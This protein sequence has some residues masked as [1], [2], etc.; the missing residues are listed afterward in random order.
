MKILKLERHAY[1]PE[2]N[3]IHLVNGATIKAPHI[4]SVREFREKIFP[5]YVRYKRV[6]EVSV[7]ND[8]Y[9]YLNRVY[10]VA[11]RT[12]KDFMRDFKRLPNKHNVNGTTIKVTSVE[13]KFRALKVI[14]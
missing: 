14:Q 2:L 10:K 8:T 11:Y 6:I 12:L 7:T 13:S 9:E 1:A 3:C 5:R 4:T